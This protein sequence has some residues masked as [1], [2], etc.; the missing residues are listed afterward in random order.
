MFRR[1]DDAASY[2]REHRDE[3]ALV[4][5]EPSFF[6]GL[7]LAGPGLA[8]ADAPRPTHV[9]LLGGETTSR[10]LIV[11][12]AARGDLARLADL[13]GGSL[14]VADV[15][16]E[17]TALYLEHTVFE[18]EI[19]PTTW[20]GKLERTVDDGAALA[21]VLFGGM[22]AA[23]VDQR[24]PLLRQRQGDLRV[25]FVGPAASLPILALRDGAVEPSRRDAYD[26]AVAELA[27]SA[28]AD[29]LEVLA[30]DGFRPLA[31]TSVVEL[32]HTP[33]R[34][35][36]SF[37]IALPPPFGERPSTALHPP[38]PPSADDL[39]FEIVPDLPRFPFPEE[40]PP[41]EATPDVAGE[42]V[43]RQKENSG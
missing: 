9:G 14:A 7:G 38:D 41:E 6:L 29:L 35:A 26:G 30:L 24:H 13:R 22:D 18:D 23:L 2:Y 39:P 34:V 27:R 1:F 40:A 11:T 17:A 15:A 16:G 43:H 12:S 8:A 21:A 5:A 20:L 3:I 36:K 19:V 31:A 10:R 4:L 25:L 37:E 28:A 32:L 33:E 42:G